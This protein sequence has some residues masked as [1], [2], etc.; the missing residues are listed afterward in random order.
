VFLLRHNDVICQPIVAAAAASDGVLLRPMSV[1]FTST[2]TKTL[3]A[4]NKLKKSF[5]R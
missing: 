3:L 2:K 1:L 4:T 5:S